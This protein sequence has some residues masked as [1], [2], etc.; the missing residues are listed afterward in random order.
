MFKIYLEG[1]YLIVDKV[2]DGFLLEIPVEEAEIIKLKSSAFIYDIRHKMKSKLKVALE[3]LLDKDGNAYTSDVFDYF[4]FNFT[5]FPEDYSILS[6]EITK[7][8][9]QDFA[10]SATQSTPLQVTSVNGGVL[11]LTC[12]NGGT[13]TDGNTN[14]NENTTMNRVIDIW[15]T[16]SNTI[17]FKDTGVK[18]NQNIFAR[19]HVEIAANVVPADFKIVLDFY[20]EENAGGTKVFSLEK[21]LDEITTSAGSYEEYIEEFRFFIGESILNGSATI[22]IIGTKAFDIKVV[23]FNFLIIG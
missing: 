15:N 8:G 19:I 20:S 18:A 23:G 4:R 13:L 12:D 2:G 14:Y 10:D 21:H 17:Q 1:K 22:N 3:L 9:W 7:S 5:G 16:T 11:Q 6:D